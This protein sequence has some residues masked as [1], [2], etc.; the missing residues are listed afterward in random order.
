MKVE[1]YRHQMGVD[2]AVAWR[3]VLDTVFLTLG[4]KVEAF[5]EELAKFLVRGLEGVPGSTSIAPHVVG[6]NSCSMGLLLALKALGVGPGDEVITTA[7]TFAAT[8]SA[9]LHLGARPVLV[10]VERTTG[11]IEPRAVEAAISPRTVGILPVHLYGQL[12]DMRALY[13]I[14]NRHSLFIVEDSA[15]GVEM[16][17]D[18]V[19]PGDLSDCA[20]FSFYATKNLTSGDGG[21]I[22][23]RNSTLADR[24]RRLRNHGMSR[25][26]SDR[27][28]SVHQHW[29]MVEL[30]YKANM[31][32]LDAAVLM[33][34]LPKA[35]TKRE[36]RE[37]LANRYEAEL[38][39]RVLEIGLVKRCGQSSHHLFTIQIVDSVAA[40]GQRRDAMLVDLK[41]AGIGTAVNYRAIHTL[42]YLKEKLGISLGALPN[43]EAIGNATLSLPLYPTLLET[44]QQYVID[45]VVANWRRA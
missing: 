22:S 8:A 32:D 1:F 30:G 21:A 39:S 24:L 35:E 45:A 16:E 3:Q 36:K 15:H 27:H 38:S 6:T 11:L 23:T 10:D 28:L 31:T 17:R 29:D 14:A 9:I 18:G 43:A 13:D 41:T 40:H 4:P 19:R 34:Q 25:S 26:A 37:Q 7:M 2:E 42:T 33:A 12:A 5:E 44:E 20:V